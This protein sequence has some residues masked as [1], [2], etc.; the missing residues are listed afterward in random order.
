MTDGRSDC[1][2][3]AQLLA[4]SPR[5][6]QVML[7]LQCSPFGQT[8]LSLHSAVL[9]LVLVLEHAEQLLG[10]QPSMLILFAEE[11]LVELGRLSAL[12]GHAMGRQIHVR[13][14]A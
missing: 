4:R 7:T 12:P 14:E 3:T 6:G 11:L 10:K 2:T 5:E 8:I 9:E 1:N 13:S